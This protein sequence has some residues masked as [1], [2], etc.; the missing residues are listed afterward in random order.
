MQ[1]SF[2][3]SV[4][5]PASLDHQRLGRIEYRRSGFTGEILQ[6]LPIETERYSIVSTLFV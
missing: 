6:S 5:V 4:F 1:S 3:L 2:A